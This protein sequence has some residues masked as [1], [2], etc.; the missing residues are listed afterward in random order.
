MV[1]TADQKLLAN[2]KIESRVI[3][4]NKVVISGQENLI[5]FRE[6]INFSKGIKLNGNRSNS[7]WK[8]PLKKTS[9]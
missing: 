5:R 7:I 2:L 4:P 3:K 8:K 1:L 9:A 6:K